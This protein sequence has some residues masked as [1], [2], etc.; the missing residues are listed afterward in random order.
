MPYE[1]DISCF[2]CETCY[3]HHP[4]YPYHIELIDKNKDHTSYLLS[5]DYYNPSRMKEEAKNEH[6]LYKQYIKYHFNK[7]Q[8]EK[9]NEK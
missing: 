1:P 4:D 2:L 9:D 6:Q 8:K 5:F 7:K 3:E